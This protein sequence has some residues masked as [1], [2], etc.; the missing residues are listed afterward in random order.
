MSC[1]FRCL[2]AGLRGLGWRFAHGQILRV[3]GASH[4]RASAALSILYD[5]TQVGS[6]LFGFCLLVYLVLWMLLRL[7]ASMA[8]WGVCQSL[9]LSPTVLV[10]YFSV[11]LRVGELSL[12]PPPASLY[13]FFAEC[14]SLSGCLSL[15]LSVDAVL[16][17][18][19]SPSLSSASVSLPVF[20]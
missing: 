14:L 20:V 13:S 11:C 18:C 9:S 7:S 17:V 5:E 19:L 15:P 4:C 1:L 10:D 2:S 12:L 3:A 8:S 6:C 16:S